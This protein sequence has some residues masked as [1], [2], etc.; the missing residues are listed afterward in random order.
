MFFSR[1]SS[2]VV[3]YITFMLA[4]CSLVD[5]E[6]SIPTVRNVGGSITTK[7]G[8]DQYTSISKPRKKV[9]ETYW[10]SIPSSANSCI[11][12]FKFLKSES[13]D[14]FTEFETR[15]S[16]ISRIYSFLNKNK[17]IMDPDA[18]EVLSMSLNMRLNTL[19]EEIKYKGYQLVKNKLAAVSDGGTIASA[20]N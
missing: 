5:T 13:P 8:H 2:I 10:A 7:I 16:K 19:C 11:D 9:P 3:F 12:N 18:R 20:G 17:N 6:S 1:F 15:Y 14:D 4:G